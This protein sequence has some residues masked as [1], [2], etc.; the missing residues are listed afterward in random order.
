MKD[1]IVRRTRPA[2]RGRSV[3]VREL[4]AHAARILRDVREARASYVVTHRGR[5]VG[6]ILPIDAGG[7]AAPTSH[8]PD[9]VTAWDTFLRAGHRLERRFAPG[10]SGVR[11][12]SDMRR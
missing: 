8:G 9:A 2:A 10:D 12:L 1:H 4:K 6:L 3:G 7:D 5:A 11:L